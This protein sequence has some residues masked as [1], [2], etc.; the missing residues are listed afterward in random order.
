[1]ADQHELIEQMG[2]IHT[3]RTVESFRRFARVPVSQLQD[4]S[5]KAL[6]ENWGSES[7]ALLHY[8]AV[9]T[10]WSIEQGRYSSDGDRLY[11]AAGN[12]KT[13]YGT[14]IYLIYVPNQHPQFGGGTPPWALVDVCTEL[15]GVDPPVPPEIPTPPP[16]DLQLEVVL[17]HEHILG[18]NEDRVSFLAQTP[19]VAQMCAVAGAVQW[20]LFRLL[21]LPYWYCG[22]MNYLV[23][24]Y[25]TSRE[26][27]TLAPDLVAPIEVQAGQLLVRT[28]M[29]PHWPYARA[30]VAVN[31]H[32]QLP[33]WML[34]AWN[35]EAERM[36]QET[37]DD[38]EGRES[39]CT[40]G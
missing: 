32:D 9:Q 19:P 39:G 24:L 11:V 3:N 23:P 1:M 2:P 29:V 17:Q 20:S 35:A 22:R 18:G 13:R 25:L 21:Q 37:I 30:R 16:V 4:L 34:N 8:I 10:R 12:L 7:F 5:Q 27:I 38:P 26:N 6:S 31:R 33:P 15:Y 14:P 40:P 28:V 36:E